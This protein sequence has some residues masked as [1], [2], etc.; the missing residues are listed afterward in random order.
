[1]RNVG[2]IFGFPFLVVD[3]VKDTLERGIPVPEQG[4]QAASKFVSS[5]FP[6]VSW[7]NGGDGVGEGN[8]GFQTVRLAIELHAVGG[9]IIPWEVGKCVTTHGE[10]TLVSEIMDRQTRARHS[11]PARQS[12]LMVQK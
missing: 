9:K 8:P 7:A 3:T 1:M 6:G 4:V 11:L 12:A 2:I 5:D 10:Q